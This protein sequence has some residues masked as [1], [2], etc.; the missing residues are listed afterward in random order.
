MNRILITIFNILACLVLSVFSAHSAQAS[1]GGFP[2][3]TAF[4]EKEYKKSQII[5]FANITRLSA[6][7]GDAAFL[8]EVYNAYEDAIT[9]KTD[10][11]F[12]QSSEI[13]SPTTGYLDQELITDISFLYSK[14]YSEPVKHL[15]E[16]LERAKLSD[17]GSAA[18]TL[19]LL[20]ALG[21]KDVSAVSLGQRMRLGGA[22]DEPDEF[23]KQLQK[24]LEVNADENLALGVQENFPPAHLYSFVRGHP[25]SFDCDSQEIASFNAPRLFSRLEN[26]QQSFDLL[27]EHLE[28]GD[29][30]PGVFARDLGFLLANI[31]SDCKYHTGKLERP[32]GINDA[33]LARELVYLSA[34]MSEG[35]D[36][37]PELAAAW[38]LEIDKGPEVEGKNDVAARLILHGAAGA[39]AQTYEDA[40]FERFVEPLSR[41]T[42]VEAQ[43]RL[44]TYDFY[45]SSLDGIPGP[46]FRRGIKN[47][48]SCIDDFGKQRPEVCWYQERKTRKPNWL[49]PFL[50]QP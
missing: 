15:V 38:A 25:S 1:C 20:G 49:I 41:E 26:P 8:E 12:E 2:S 37:S 39:W 32:F 5:F 21:W 50:I 23:I 47:M 18:T 27:V 10:S 29:M 16:T 30:E 42:I 43:R 17:N 9:L 13:I 33:E 40:F 35:M 22:F 28:D 11:I 19:A 46:G 6:N 24:Q 44:Q 7:C 45:T 3:G 31:A 36:I 14:G 34:Q 48:A 4:F